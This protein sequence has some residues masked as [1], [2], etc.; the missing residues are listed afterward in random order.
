MNIYT[1]L[2]IPQ[3]IYSTESKYN[4]KIDVVEVGRTRKIKVNGIDQSLNWNSPVCEKLVWGKAVS[5]LKRE[6]PELNSV[7]VLGL[8]G[9]TIQ[10]LISR[11]LPSAHVT[12]VEIDSVMVDIAT[13]YFDLDKIPNHRVIVSDALR[14]VASPEEFELNKTSFNAAIVDIYIGEDYP[15]LGKSGNFI[16]AVRDMIVPGGLVVFNRIYTKHH[17]DDVDLF[18]EQVQD[19]LVDVRTEI[20]AGYTNSDNILVYGRIFEHDLGV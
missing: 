1:A 12:S 13:K 18:I 16:D 6:E 10:Q 2:K 17:H 3:V 4:G 11:E 15:D 5:L 14:V 8:G 9:G 20:V 19:F 7:L